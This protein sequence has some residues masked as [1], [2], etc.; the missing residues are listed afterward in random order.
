MSLPTGI[1]AD[2]VTETVI[3]DY[4]ARMVAYHSFAALNYYWPGT[5]PAEVER[6]GRALH[7]Q[8]IDLY[9]SGL[10]LREHVRKLLGPRELTKRQRKSLC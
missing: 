9:L 6:R 3:A 4:Q 5:D 2:I 10:A 1:P 7:E 8:H